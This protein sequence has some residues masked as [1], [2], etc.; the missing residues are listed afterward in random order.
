[1]SEPSK[2]SESIENVLH[3][4]FGFDRRSSIKGNTCVPK[5]IGCGGPAVEFK[6][7]C[8]RREYRISGL[9]QKCQDSFFG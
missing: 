3:S 2:K 9:C 5:P 7:D 1:M 6:D 4:T 8:S